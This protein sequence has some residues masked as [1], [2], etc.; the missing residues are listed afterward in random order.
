MPPEP[1]SKTWSHHLVQVGQDPDVKIHYVDCPP[2]SST[3]S[4]SSTSRTLLLIHGFPQTWYEFR[5]A[6]PAFTALG[7][8]VIA[9][10][11]R[12]AGASSRPIAGYDKM[13]MG[14]DLGDLVTTVLKLNK[15]LVLG[16]DIGSMVA[17]GL[18]LQYRDLVEG[19]MIMG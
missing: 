4:P 19:L 1:Q 9:A 17:V 18:T 8:R 3:A 5:H 10:D 15:I 11:Y 14:K 12:G 7:L 2:T 13:T 6:I 16:H